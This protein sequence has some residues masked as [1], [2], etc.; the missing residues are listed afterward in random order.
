MNKDRT[1]LPDTPSTITLSDDV[2]DD[3]YSDMQ[4]DQ[5]LMLEQ[6]GIYE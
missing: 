1:K 5:A 4:A 6:S 2:L 3:I